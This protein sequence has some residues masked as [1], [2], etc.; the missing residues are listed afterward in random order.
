MASVKL[1]KHSMNFCECIYELSS[2]KPVKNALGLTDGSIDKTKKFIR[3]IIQEEKEGK[4]LSRVLLDENSNVIGIT[5]LMSIN[6]EKKSCHIGTWIGF[7]YWGKGYNE[8]SKIAI[9]RIA[10]EDLGLEK[11]FAGAR[12]I[13]I[14]SQ[15]AQ[16]KLPFIRLYVEN[17]FPEEH[18]ALEEK[19]KEPCVLHAFF[20]K[21]F[22]KY[23]QRKN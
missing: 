3:F 9:L 1:A 14:R 4:T 10:F 7:D 21:D 20:K 6:D 15:K 16:E 23:L 11:V 13:N 12:K 19:A 22:I 5:T 17:E 18:A 2:A 8:A